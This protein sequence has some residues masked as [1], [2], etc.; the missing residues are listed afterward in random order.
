MEYEDR[1]RISTP[2]GVE[3]ELTLAGIGSRFTASLI[4]HAIQGL[5]VVASIALF[6][7][8]ADAEVSGGQ[9]EGNGGGSLALGAAVVTLWSFLV[10]FVY[11]VLFEVRAGGRTPGKRLTGLRVVRAGGQPVGF[12][13]SAIRNVVRLVD[14]LPPPY[15]IGMAVMFASRRNQRLGDLAAGTVVV[16]ERTGGRDRRRK[17]AA[18]PRATNIPIDASGW[19]VSGVS[20]EDVAT[21]RRFLERRP[22]ITPAARRELAGDL[23]ARLRPRV[24]GAP[25]D[26]A[27]ETFLEA[28]A[29]AKAARS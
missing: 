2:E 23:A 8:L 9:V 21:V 17:T 1:L 18:V 28:L 24:V 25:D 26:L 20:A 22:E 4:D 16:R 3:L 7:R 6:T 19:D 29:D 10:F 13:T 27:P 15:G 5:L 12:V 14:A 11:D